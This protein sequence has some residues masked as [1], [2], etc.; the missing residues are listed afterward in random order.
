M[1]CDV[2]EFTANEDYFYRI[3][4]LA[5]GGCSGYDLFA[6]FLGDEQKFV[7]LLP[8]QRVLIHTNISMKI[9]LGFEG[10]VRSKSGLALKNGLMVL[11]S[12]GTIDSSYR[13]ELCVILFNS[14]HET[15]RIEEGMKVAQLV[16][17]KIEQPVFKKVYKLDDTE[18]GSGGFGSTGLV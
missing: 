2:V 3:P 9:P 8:N 10:Q 13:G 1:I 14:S 7:N 15:F 18:R 17:Q 6:S 5:D 16:F 4:E 11:N 12:P